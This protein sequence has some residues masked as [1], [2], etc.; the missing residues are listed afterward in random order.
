MGEIIISPIVS[1]L[2]SN[3]FLMELMNQVQDFGMGS[4]RAGLSWVCAKQMFRKYLR[5]EERSEDEVDGG[6][7]KVIILKGNRGCKI[8]YVNNEGVKWYEKFQRGALGRGIFSHTLYLTVDS[9]SET[10]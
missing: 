2:L 9:H 1:K 8:T 5:N 10:A 6:L 4:V 3:V 7:I